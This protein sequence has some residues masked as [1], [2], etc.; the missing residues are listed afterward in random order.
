LLRQISVSAVSS[1]KSVGYKSTQH[2][3]KNKK[4]PPNRRI[5]HPDS[6]GMHIAFVVPKPLALRCGFAGA[7]TTIYDA[8]GGADR[9]RSARKTSVLCEC[10]VPKKY[11]RSRFM[12]PKSVKEQ[13]DPKTAGKRKASSSAQD[14]PDANSDPGKRMSLYRS[15]GIA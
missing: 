6:D 4:S 14:F 7:I 15:A 12:L 11:H 9:R 5:A 8:S 10:K 2:R 13:N 3:K 1:Q